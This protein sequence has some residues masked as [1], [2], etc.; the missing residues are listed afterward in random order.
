MSPLW[1]PPRF[2]Y[3]LLLLDFSHIL[4]QATNNTS[5][6]QSVFNSR[7]NLGLILPYA[8]TNVTEGGQPSDCTGGY[9]N[10]CRRL[11]N[12][13]YV[14]RAVQY[15]TG[16]RVILCVCEGP[17]AGQRLQTLA[18]NFSRVS[19][20]PKNIEDN[21]QIIHRE[22]FASPIC[23]TYIHLK[24]YACQLKCIQQCHKFELQASALKI[25][26]SRLDCIGR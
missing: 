17:D 7:P 15:S 14:T 8:T 10:E 3:C 26:T 16:R 19:F 4:G 11:H 13:T 6:R 25:Y 9:I 12:T 21:V 5:F 23:S 24:T 18:D 22:R 1:Y 2:V 20:R